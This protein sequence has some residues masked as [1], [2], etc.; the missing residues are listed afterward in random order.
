MHDKGYNNPQKLE[1]Y[2]K[3]SYK[4]TEALDVLENRSTNEVLFGGGA[5][6]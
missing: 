3:L 6:I 1:A 4:Q 5:G 2:M